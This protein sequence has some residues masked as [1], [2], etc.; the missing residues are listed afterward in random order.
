[1]EISGRRFVV[2]GMGKS[3]AAAAHFLKERGARV[4]INDKKSEYAFGNKIQALKESGVRIK[5]GSHDPDIFEKADVVVLS[6]GVPHTMAPVLAAEKR[7]AKI[8]GE[9]E[10]ASRFIKEDI[11]AVTGTNGKTTTTSLIGE[12]L[13]ESGFNVFVGGNIGNPLIGYVQEGKKADIVVAEVSSFQLDTIVAFRPKVA[14]LLNITEDHLDRYPDFNAYADSKTKIFEN[15]KKE[16][17]AVLNAG[18]KN[19]RRAAQNIRSRKLFYNSGNPDQDNIYW[20]DDSFVVSFDE[21]EEIRIG[22]SSPGIYGKH[23]RENVSA[24]ILASLAS[25]GH[26]QGLKQ[27]LDRFSGL[28]HRLEFVKSVDGIRFFND[29]KATNTDAVKRALESFEES[30]VILIMG[31][32][33]KG[34]RFHTLF[35]TIK[36]HVR[37]IVAMGESKDEIE[38]EFQSIV[39]VHNTRDM[40]EAVKKSYQS[41]KAGDVVLLSPA[42]ASFD[43]FDDYAH[44]GNIFCQEVEKLP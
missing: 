35:D 28:S 10:L 7:G 1:M 36:K 33:A 22:Q 24:A 31:G 19:I 20:N 27:A 14:V 13:K 42:C 37:A 21:N 43:M 41:A 2:V 29:S 4:T 17:F 15:Q 18:D 11:V 3:G 25:G 32:Q 38:S 16:D 6:P 44:R 26:T 39:P 34:C 23:N 5:L 30:P 12:M 40:A 9:M 8:I